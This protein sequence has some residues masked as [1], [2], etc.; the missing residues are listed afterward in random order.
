MRTVRNSRCLRGEGWYPSM[1]WGRPP[2]PRGQTDGC[3]NI[4]FAT[5]S[6]K[7]RHS[8]CFGPR[9]C[10]AMT[11]GLHSRFYHHALCRDLCISVDVFSDRTSPQS[12]EATCSR[13]W[14]ILEEKKFP[15]ALEMWLDMYQNKNIFVAFVLRA[16]QNEFEITTF[17]YLESEISFSGYF[18]FIFYEMYCFDLI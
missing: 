18:L 1:H 8:F 17:F 13:F 5:H 2:A 9:S 16:L 14:V 15:K 3:K 11:R 10:G 7:K 4:T 12:H 6:P